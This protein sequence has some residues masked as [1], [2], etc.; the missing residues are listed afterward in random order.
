MNVSDNEIKQVLQDCKKIC[1]LGLSPDPHKPSH[2]VPAYMR[3]QGFDV[4]G[5]YPQQTDAGGFSIYTSLK[6][7]PP[8]YRRFINVF[9]RSEKI[10][11][12]VEEVLE[13]GGTEVLWLQLGITHAAAEKTAEQA[14]LKVISNRCLLIEYNNFF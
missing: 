3:D 4:V 10:P 7:V 12:V 6:D 14:G 1:V 8:E 11:E 5:V 2:S 9:R 13:L